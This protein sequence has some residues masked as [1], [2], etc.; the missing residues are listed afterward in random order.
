MTEKKQNKTVFAVINLANTGEQQKNCARY[1]AQMAK[2]LG[3]DLVLYPQIDEIQIS[4]E[5]GVRRVAD[6][7]YK[8]NGVC[9]VRVSERR[10]KTFFKPAL[11]ILQLFTSFASLHSIAKKENAGF[12]I[13]GTKE[14]IGIKINQKNSF[15]DVVWDTTEKSDILI[16]I[17]P[18]DIE[19]SPFK[20]ITIAMDRERK[21][22]KMNIATMFAKTFGSTIH[23]FLENP[24]EKS[25]EVTNEIMLN[26]IKKKL[27][28]EKI[29]FKVTL[30]RSKKDF[31]K[32]LCLITAKRSN[33]LLIEVEPGTIKSAVKDSIQ[34]V[35]D[36]K[37]N[38]PVLFFKTQPM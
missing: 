20:Q 35:F 19:F 36:T 14:D 33:L 34:E 26:H 32:N 29:P 2:S 21:L 18:H 11:T 7:A 3:M 16:M 27:C 24:D 23:I 15:T 30:A 1:A 38:F 22:S 10:I 31:A 13:M 5:E 25:I 6:I 9:E 8:I 4:F 37:G 12:I 17:L 28:L